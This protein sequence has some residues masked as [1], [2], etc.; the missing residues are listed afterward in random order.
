MTFSRNLLRKLCRQTGE[1]QVNFRS[2]SSGSSQGTGE[3]GARESPKEQEEE[4]KGGTPKKQERETVKGEI[5]I[6]KLGSNN[7]V[8]F[9]IVKKY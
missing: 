1:L 7:I 9:C 4:E 2:P 6:T 5:I 3:R 8:L